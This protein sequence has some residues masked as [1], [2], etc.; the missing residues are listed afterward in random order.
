MSE[1]I[2]YPTP[3]L[4]LVTPAGIASGSATPGVSEH[5]RTLGRAV[6]TSE[7][8]I[9]RRSH[10]MSTITSTPPGASA[11]VPSPL[12]RMTLEE[13]EAMVASGV[14]KARNRFHLINGFLVAKMTQNPPHTIADDLCGSRWPVS[15]RLDIR[16]A[17]PVRLP[18]SG[19]QNEPDRCVVRGQ[20]RNYGDSIPARPT[21]P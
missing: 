9:L 14:F 16:P 15:A 21:S 18:G 11:W 13:Y 12:Y 5:T 19:Q 6:P 1:V 2:E 4:S 17:K 3:D 20:V 7:K 8:T 10:P